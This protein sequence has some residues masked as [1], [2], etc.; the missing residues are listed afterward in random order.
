[1]DTQA[2]SLRSLSLKTN[3]AFVTGCYGS[4]CAPCR[5]VVIMYFEYSLYISLHGLRST[6]YNITHYTFY[7]NCFLVDYNYL[8][9]T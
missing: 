5:F 3:S 7:K 2:R 1:M 4:G 9:K 6:V 8:D